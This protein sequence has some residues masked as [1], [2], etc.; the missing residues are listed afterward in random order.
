[1]KFLCDQMLV[2]LGRWLR[3]AGYD[4]EIAQEGLSDKKILENA[5]KDNRFL[6]TRD[7]HFLEMGKADA[8]VIWLNSNDINGCINELSTRI[9]INWLLNPFSRCLECNSPLHELTDEDFV[10]P[11]PDVVERGLPVTYCPTCHKTY[12][13]GSHTSRML[14]QLKTFME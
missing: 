10:E 3:A 14:S 2:R 8:L 4:T 9:K 5:R 13:P 7:K 1:M 12:W 6:I 11:P